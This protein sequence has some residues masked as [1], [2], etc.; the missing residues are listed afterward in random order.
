MTRIQNIHDPTRTSDQQYL[1]MHEY[2]LEFMFVNL[3]HTMGILVECSGMPL[4]LMD[5]VLNRRNWKI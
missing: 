1:V 2:T 4:T 3:G 5:D